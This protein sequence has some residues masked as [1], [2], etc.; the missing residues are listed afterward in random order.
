MLCSFNPHLRLYQQPLPPQTFGGMASPVSTISLYNVTDRQVS[1]ECRS[2]PNGL[3]NSYPPLV[4][5][6]QELGVSAHDTDVRAAAGANP[7]P[8]HPTPMR[9]RINV[10][11]TVLSGVTLDHERRPDVLTSRIVASAP[12]LPLPAQQGWLVHSSITGSIEDTY[13]PCP[14]SAAGL[15]QAVLPVSV[16]QSRDVG[17]S[18]PTPTDTF[19]KPKLR[20]CTFPS[21]NRSFKR[22]DHLKRHILSH[23]GARPFKCTYPGCEKSFTR[24]DNFLQH[25]RIHPGQENPRSNKYKSLRGLGQAHTEN[26]V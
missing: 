2:L 7:S 22:S 23:T 19:V 9:Y 11:F 13:A 10:P 20:R 15:D 21:C 4:L 1:G 3:L 5:F 24:S 14:A 6:Q 25:E 12:S 18:T 16:A 17:T 8:L 26:R